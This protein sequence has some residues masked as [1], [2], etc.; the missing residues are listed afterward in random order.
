MTVTVT[1]THWPRAGGTGSLW[2]SEP[3]RDSDQCHRVTVNSSHLLSLSVAVT[4]TQSQ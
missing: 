4:Q 1:V 3:A 2:Q